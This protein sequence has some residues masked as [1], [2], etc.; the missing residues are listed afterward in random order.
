VFLYLAYSAPL[1]FFLSISSSLLLSR[2]SQPR[3]RVKGR[4]KRS[5]LF[6]GF[7]PFSPQTLQAIFLSPILVLEG[8]RPLLASRLC[9]S[10]W[11]PHGLFCALDAA[12]GTKWRSPFFC[13]KRKPRSHCL[14]LRIPRI[15][16]DPQFEASLVNFT[17]LCQT[18]P[19]PFISCGILPP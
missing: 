4:A 5:T 7:S 2:L 3:R 17:C 16:K 6:S 18:L 12:D 11:T 8:K 9:L 15:L 19:L 14:H 10:F 13:G 1:S